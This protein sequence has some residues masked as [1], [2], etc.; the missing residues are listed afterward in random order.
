MML[1]AP[2]AW[3]QSRALFEEAPKA[4][5]KE[6]ETTLPTYP[7]SADLIPFSVSPA[8]TARF[9]IDGKSLRLGEDGV[10]RF[11]LLVRA[12]GGAE[13]LSYE[14]IRCDT[15]ER[16][17][18]ATGRGNGEWARVRSEAWLRIEDNSRN[19][20]H[21]VLAKDFFCPPSAARPSVTEIIQSLRREAGLR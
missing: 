5:W 16:K 15:A 10:L 13:N 14:G 1:S 12:A 4:E 11:T 18:Y 9:F 2:V 7:A 8:A 3:A 17:L 20:Q 6:V 19:R 21:A